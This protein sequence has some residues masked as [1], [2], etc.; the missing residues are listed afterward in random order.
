MG[1]HGDR[2][3]RKAFNNYHLWMEE[4]NMITYIIFVFFFHVSVNWWKINVELTPQITSIILCSAN[5]RHLHKI[6]K[7]SVFKE[8]KF[9]LEMKNMYS[10]ERGVNII[11]I[12]PSFFLYTFAFVLG[13]ISLDHFLLDC[14]FQH[15]HTFFSHLHKFLNFQ[16]C[17][18]I[19]FRIT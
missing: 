11:N 8:L 5:C 13:R 9:K 7:S 17:P 10:Q 18:S 3:K 16:K 12:G 15:L 14:F 19:I 2:R 6:S 4:L 1:L